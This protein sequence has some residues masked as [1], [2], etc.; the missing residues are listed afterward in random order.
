M[1]VLERHEEQE[2]TLLATYIESVTLFVASSVA[3]LVPLGMLI[4]LILLL[5]AFGRPNTAVPLAFALAPTLIIILIALRIVMAVVRS[6]TKSIRRN[7][8][9]LRS[10]IFAEIG[11]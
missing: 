1:S 9:G 7:L 2:G 8:V 6:H 5:A 3:M 11:M 4:A 10:D